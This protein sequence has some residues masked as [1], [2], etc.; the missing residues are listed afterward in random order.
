MRFTSPQ[1]ITRH[2]IA[3][4]VQLSTD[5]DACPGDGEILIPR[6][7]MPDDVLHGSPAEMLNLATKIAALY[8]CEV[9]KLK[10]TGYGPEKK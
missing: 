3:P 6:V 1:D 8:G 2:G 9:V 4:I 5:G 10:A 7:G